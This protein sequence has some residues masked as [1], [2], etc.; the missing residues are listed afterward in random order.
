LSARAVIQ[1]TGA[2]CAVGIGTEQTWASI[3]AGIARFSDSSVHDR[4]FEPVRMALLPEDALE[5]L[6]PPVDKI[7]F[8]SRRR[9]MLRLAAPALRQALKGLQGPPPPLFIGLP[10]TAPEPSGLPDTA[11]V[12]ALAVQCAVPFDKGTTQLFPRGRAAALL[13]LEAAMKTLDERRLETVVV[14]GVDTYLDLALLGELGAEGRILG[15]RVMDGFIPGEGAAFVVLA[16]PGGRSQPHPGIAVVSAGTAQDP[17][18]RYSAQPAK[19]EGLSFAI[20]RML[21]ALG[22]SPIPLQT[23]FAGFNGENFGAKEWGVARIR[24]AD[25]FAPTMK[26]E[27]PAD[28]F[29]DTGA[30][31]GAL[32]LAVA[33]A[34]LVTKQ[35][36][37]P[38]LIWASS[39]REDRACA[40][41]DFLA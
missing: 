23:T 39:D 35:R 3:R 11:F 30:A 13:A 2:V 19:G 7:P 28:C 25:L 27:H 40:W 24:H 36:P 6:L 10:Q 8:T 31:L 38:A 5:P 41:L 16:R 15:P 32:L 29:G 34:S 33:N 14:G 37:T 22:Q 9:R 4:W 17:G 20:E 26:L 12:D 21:S 18:H 1:A